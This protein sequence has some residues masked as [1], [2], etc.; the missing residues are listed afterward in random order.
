ML[1]LG[2][3]LCWGVLISGVLIFGPLRYRFTAGKKLSNPFDEFDASCQIQS[4][5]DE[6]PHN[7]LS[8]VFFLFQDEHVMIEELLKFLIHKV[9]PKLFKAVEL[10]HNIIIIMMLPG[11]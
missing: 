2:G 3:C 10:K 5:I 7:P 6:Y 11:P 9:D 8:L 1:I 4:E